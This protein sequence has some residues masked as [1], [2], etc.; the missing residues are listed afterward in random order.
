VLNNG[1]LTFDH[2]AVTG[3]TMATNAGD[4]WQGGDGIYNGS[5][6]IIREVVMEGGVDDPLRR[7]RA[8][9][10]AV[11]ILQRTALD[12]GSGRSKRRGGRILAR[13]AEHRMPSAE[14]LAHDGRANISGRTRN[15]N[16]HTVS[17]LGKIM[18]ALKTLHP[19]L[20]SFPPGKCLGFFLMP[21]L[22]DN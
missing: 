1:S 5:G 18:G 13:Q 20:P 19:R 15:K 11:Q 17:L 8:T 4:Y 10:Q 9:A 21:H 16:T 12:I 22:A 7:S 6:G 14:Q 2:V 3:N